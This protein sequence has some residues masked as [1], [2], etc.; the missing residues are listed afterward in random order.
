MDEQGKIENTFYTQTCV[1]VKCL[2]L[3]TESVPGPR[4]EI[5]S[6]F[7]VTYALN[8]DNDQLACV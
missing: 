4:R 1:F 7:C 6:T 3:K 2:C 5:L 8:C